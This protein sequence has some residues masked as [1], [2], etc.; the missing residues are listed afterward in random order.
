MSPESSSRALRSL[1]AGAL[2]AGMVQRL[3]SLSDKAFA[4][5]SQVWRSTIDAAGSG[6]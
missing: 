1:P 6:G 2:N 3:T 4:L 5:I